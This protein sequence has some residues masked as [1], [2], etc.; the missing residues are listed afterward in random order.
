[1]VL[2]SYS[3]ISTSRLGHGFLS[4]RGT[5]RVHEPSEHPISE[6]SSHYGTAALQEK[7][8]IRREVVAMNGHRPVERT[9]ED[10]RQVRGPLVRQKRIRIIKDGGVLPLVDAIRTSE[11]IQTRAMLIGKGQ[12]KVLVD[13]VES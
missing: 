7:Q 5:D 10:G 4:A 2:I 1:M 8:L 3:V 11:H 6:P 9:R 13:F 12:G